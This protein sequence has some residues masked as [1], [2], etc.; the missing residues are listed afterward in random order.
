M[1]LSSEYQQAQPTE[2]K[3]MK[4]M[5]AVWTNTRGT[6]MLTRR[7]SLVE[8]E[9]QLFNAESLEELAE[10]CVEAAAELRRAAAVAERGLGPEDFAE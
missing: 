5:Q 4:T 9:A 8:V 3:T 7:G 1:P 2:R 6:K 10:A